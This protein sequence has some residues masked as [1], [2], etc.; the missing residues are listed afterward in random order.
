MKWSVETAA[1]VA[2][3]ITTAGALIPFAI[4]RTLG[5]PPQDALPY[6]G[7]PALGFSALGMWILLRSIG[8]NL[9]WA[10]LLLSALAGL[11]GGVVALAITIAAVLYFAR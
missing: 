7:I 3:V 11:A 10:R 4:I 2:I 6:F 5:I 9:H 1:W 8:P